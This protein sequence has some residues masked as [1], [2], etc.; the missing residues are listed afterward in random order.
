MPELDTYE[1]DVL[2]AFEKGKLKSVATKSELAR[3]RAAAR[4]TAMTC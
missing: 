2:A 4:A 1:Q 3:L